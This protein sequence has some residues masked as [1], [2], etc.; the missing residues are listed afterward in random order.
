MIFDVETQQI[1]D[2]SNKS[3]ERLGRIR[4]AF[5][6]EPVSKWVHPD[7]VNSLPG[8]VK[9]VSQSGSIRH[10]QRWLA[11]SGEWRLYDIGSM[12]VD[13]DHIA[14]SGIDVSVLAAPD[15]QIE[16]FLRLVDIMDDGMVITD[17]AGR[18]TYLNDGAARI[19]GQTP[20]DSVGKQLISFMHPEHHDAFFKLISD[21]VEGD[22]RAQGRMTS[23]RPDG[24]SLKIDC[25]SAWDP[26]SGSWYTIGRDITAIVRQEKEL[27]EL[28]EKL[29]K[30]A[31]TDHLTGLAN[32]SAFAQHL[33]EALEGDWPFALMVIDVNEFKSVNDNFGHHTGDLLLQDLARRMRKATRVNDLVAR[34]GGDEFVILCLNTTSEETALA[35]ANEVHE[36][37]TDTFALAGEAIAASCA[38]GV[39]LG[40][41]GQ[42][43]AADLFRRADAAAYEAKKSR[44]LGQAVLRS[45]S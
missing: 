39:T 10:R 3:C 37:L 6:G 30:L 16:S 43:T 27:K 28:N 24:T 26:E 23:L 32:R 11:A 5:V 7:D 21:A 25:R 1:V 15:K 14:M 45:T 19:F 9:R 22:N 38:V 2:I 34:Y 4:E 44:A 17:G 36:N 41:P 12:L 42:D 33:D 40:H 20:E 8:I 29:H 35:R 13:P 31:S 18:I